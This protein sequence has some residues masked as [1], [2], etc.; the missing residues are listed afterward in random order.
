VHALL[1]TPL[2]CRGLSPCAGG[3]RPLRAV[4]R[5]RLRPALQ[6]AAPDGLRTQH[7]RA[8]EV[9]HRGQPVRALWACAGCGPALA[10][11]PICAALWHAAATRMSGPRSKTSACHRCAF[12]PPALS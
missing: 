1:T 11:V 8:Q 2:T 9:P 12:S 4:Q 6:H 10:V 3:A 7:G 5:A